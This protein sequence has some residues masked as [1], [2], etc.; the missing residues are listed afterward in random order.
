MVFFDSGAASSTLVP[1]LELNS[2]VM[3]STDPNGESWIQNW[4][5]EPRWVGNWWSE[6][7]EMIGISLPDLSSQS[8]L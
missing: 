8:S 5:R 2:K 1:F 4:V 3:G 6:A 7:L